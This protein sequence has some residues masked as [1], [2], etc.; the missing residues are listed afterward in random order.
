MNK[1]EEIP[2]KSPLQVESLKDD[3]LGR[4][5]Y[6]KSLEHYLDIEHEFTESSLV[7]SLN[8]KFG[9]GKSTLLKMWEND[10]LLRRGNGQDVPLVINLNAWDS[11]FYNEPLIPILSELVD[12]V[13]SYL[14]EKDQKT[15]SKLKEAAKDAAWY[16]V[17]LTNSA[18]PLD[19]LAAADFAGKKK[20]QRVNL[21]KPIRP[22]LLSD[23]KS[24]KNA[25]M[26]LKDLL[27]ETLGGDQPKAF[28]FIDELDR[29][30]PDY[31]VSYL[32]TIKHVF[33]MRGIVFVLAIDYDHLANSAKALYGN[34]LK[35]AEYFRKFVHRSFEMPEPK[36]KKIE[37]FARALTNYYLHNQKSRFTRLNLKDS[38]VRL[39]ELISATE[40][41]P[42][43]MIEFFR[44]LGHLSG[45]KEQA[46]DV[47]YLGY[48]IG[49]MLM[50]A[51][52]V[53]KKELYE[54]LGH[55]DARHEE[56][57][58]IL[59][60]E[61]QK[62]MNYW[63]FAV[64]LGGFEDK[65]GAYDLLKKH[66]LLEKEDETPQQVDSQIQEVGHYF[67]G[68]SI[69]GDRYPQIYKQIEAI[70]LE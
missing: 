69:Y 56:V 32:E 46:K 17:G 67:W 58:L 43:Q 60:N 9:S 4:E 62:K 38:W 25:I 61:M 14:P 55:G 30:R 12:A 8:A 40:M 27:K 57:L 65:S 5:S 7:V 36:P 59:T 22:D 53:A 63:W 28:V 54:S 15:K 41:S 31:A 45:S 42:R 34:Q 47:L 18:V 33:D 19:A 16:M 51:F 26:L 3:L 68:N 20:M 70:E 24:R 23:Y 49:M 48:G 2:P 1:T 11:D 21:D 37:D 52:K 64:Y 29:C 10:L 44:L 13:S 39:S 50:C 35:F 66:K 6:I